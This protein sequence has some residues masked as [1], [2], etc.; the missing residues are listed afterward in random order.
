M[1]KFLGLVLTGVLLFCT[2]FS[3]VGCGEETGNGMTEEERI[4]YENI[5]KYHAEYIGDAEYTMTEEYLENDGRLEEVNIIFTQEE[6]E[7]VFLDFPK[8]DFEKEMVLVYFYDSF[9]HYDIPLLKGITFEEDNRLQ[10]TFYMKD[11]EEALPGY[12][13]GL[14]PRTYSLVVKIDKLEVSTAEFIRIRK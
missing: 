3:I 14:P 4:A 10:I 6:L 12:A 8:V 5:E 1:R 11:M 13:T 7:E 9:Y 2:V